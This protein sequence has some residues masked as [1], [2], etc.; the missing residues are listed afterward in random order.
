[1]PESPQILYE[2]NHCLAVFKP[3]RLLTAGDATGDVSLLD[4]AKAYLKEKYRKPGNVFVG[5]VHRLDRPVSGVVL[6]A[7]TSKSASRLSEQF[8]AGTI[9][10][11]Y[12]ALVEGN[13][14]RVEV[15]LR[16]WLLKEEQSNL[17]SVVSADTPGAREC[18]LRY[19]RL[20]TGG[21]LSHIEVTPVTGRSHQIRVQLSATG[22]PILG[23][24]KY[25]S[26]RSLGGVIALHAAQLT[27]EHPIRHERITVRA[28][29]PGDWRNLLE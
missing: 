6:F 4:Q 22:H 7:R 2:D 29:A 15:E 9:E 28:E 1:M 14:S 11:R 18:L 13:V 19:R 26:T 8:R 16:H 20:A 23:D 27:F 24:R 21:G 25:G 12:E 17:V 10:K 3:A 5:L